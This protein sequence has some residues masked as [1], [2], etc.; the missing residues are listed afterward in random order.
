MNCIFVNSKLH[1]M[2]IGS[3]KTRVTVGNQVFEI[4]AEKTAELFQILSKWQS[5]AVTEANPSPPLHYQGRSLIN[6]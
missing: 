3:T 2:I 6:G 1:N 4:P 5:I